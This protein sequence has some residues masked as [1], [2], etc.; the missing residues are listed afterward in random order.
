MP[1][2]ARHPRMILIQRRAHTSTFGFQ[3]ASRLSLVAAATVATVT[4]V[5]RAG[6]LR[7]LRLRAGRLRTGHRHRHPV[8]HHRR[9]LVRRVTL[10]C[11]WLPR[12]RTDVDT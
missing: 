2:A 7:L 1:P 6:Q 11:G 3:P 12:A 4:R 10:P 9:H 8:H 5:L